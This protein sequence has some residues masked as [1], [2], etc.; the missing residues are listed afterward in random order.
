MVAAGA[1]TSVR[2]SA[3]QFDSLNHDYHRAQ[4]LAIQVEQQFQD[5]SSMVFSRSP[6]EAPDTTTISVWNFGEYGRRL[7]KV[8]FTVVHLPPHTTT[9]GDRYPWAYIQKVTWNST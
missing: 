3:S 8:K 6:Q 5:R 4:S 1:R 7:I 9:A 2:L